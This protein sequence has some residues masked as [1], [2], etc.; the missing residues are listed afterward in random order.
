VAIGEV[1]PFR[2]FDNTTLDCEGHRIGD[3]AQGDAAVVAW[4]DNIVLKY[5]VVV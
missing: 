1:T 3:L 2:L 5:C 4:G